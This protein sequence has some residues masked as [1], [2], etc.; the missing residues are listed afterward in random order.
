MPSLHGMA[1]AGRVN[2][3]VNLLVFVGA[4]VAQWGMGAIVNLWP[5]D[6]GRYPLIAYTAAFGACVAAQLCA[7]LPLLLHRERVV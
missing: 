1:L 7:L 4:F 2:T 6:A 3:A 5:A